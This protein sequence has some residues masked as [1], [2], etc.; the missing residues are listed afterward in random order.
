M[1]DGQKGKRRGGRGE[2]RGIEG[3]GRG[4]IRRSKKGME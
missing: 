4:V 2:E 3:A 1:K